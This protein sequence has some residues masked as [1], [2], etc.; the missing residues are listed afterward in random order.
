MSLIRI[1]AFGHSHLGALSMAY[2]QADG[3]RDLP[4]ELTTYQFLG[5][6]RPQ[7]VNPD[8]KAWRYHPEIERDILELINTIEPQAVVI[9]MHGEQAVSAGLIAPA[10]PY[11]FYFPR[12]AG[13]IPNAA[14]EIIPFDLVLKVF[15]TRYQI[16][17]NFIDLIRDKLPPLSFALS[18]PPPVGDRQFIIDSNTKHGNI[19]CHIKK[20][21]L[22]ATAWRHRI[23]KIN[24]MA[25]RTIY[26]ARSIAF[27]DPPDG[28][29][30]ENGCLHV[31]FRSD[32]FH[33]NLAYG[34]LLLGQI[35]SLLGE[36]TSALERHE[37]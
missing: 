34:E 19:S 28:T 33:A 6:D 2:L 4:Y 22:P 16:I 30:D 27:I 10:K 1:L 32:L 21:G 36:N 23:W 8:G 3:R 24:M 37:T 26:D 7:I 25:M 13:Y 35:G 9:M 31:N 5:G 18:P 20:N 12:E 29:A 15:I 14:S 17:A 11:D